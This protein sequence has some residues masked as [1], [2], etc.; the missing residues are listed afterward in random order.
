VTLKLISLLPGW[1]IE[2]VAVTIYLLT[3]IF[4]AR[5]RR[6]ICGNAERVLRLTPKEAQVFARQVLQQQLIIYVETLKYIFDRKSVK[7][8]GLEELSAKIRP[9]QSYDQGLVVITAHL[10]AWELAGHFCAVAS[11]QTLVVLAKPNKQKWLNPLL[12]ELR[13]RLQMKV[14][15]SHSKSVL[16]DMLN[17]LD[18]KG[19]LGFVMDQRPAQGGFKVE[20][21]GIPE[22]PM[23]AGPAAVIVKKNVPVVGAYCVRIGPLHYRVLS[24]DI[25]PANHGCTDP[26]EVTVKLSKSM[27][28]AIRLYPQ[29]WAWNYKRWK[30]AFRV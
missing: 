20:F 22:T 7:I 27:E 24:D 14:L 19:G 15:W 4:T 12:A 18:A 1:S 26:Q 21:L 2:P 17:T 8:D 9:S 29:Q 10:G 3:W 28:E 25:L 30:H 13:A 6:I 11:G 16:R 5:D 23:V